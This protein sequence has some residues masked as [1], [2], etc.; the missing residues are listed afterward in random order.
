MLNK[1]GEKSQ[2][3]TFISTLPY[4]C[5]SSHIQFS[6][7]MFKP[8]PFPKNGKPRCNNFLFWRTQHSCY[9]WV[10]TE[11][12]RELWESIYRNIKY[13]HIV[14]TGGSVNE[15]PYI[16]KTSHVQWTQPLSSTTTT[17]ERKRGK[18][19]HTET[20][21]LVFCA[22][23]KKLLCGCGWVKKA[24]LHGWMGKSFANICEDRL[25]IEPWM[26]A[27]NNCL[28]LMWCVSSG[29]INVTL[30]TWL[31]LNNVLSTVPELKINNLNCFT[32]S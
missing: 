22:V 18:K 17:T 7:G 20:Y 2:F 26:I 3:L 6:V 13:M 1:K 27:E 32:R 19:R 4:T 11:S 30:S 12:L 16:L 25:Y 14:C 28:Q 15:A 24:L 10:G 9:E 21:S 5:Y 31:W 8:K 23:R 29:V